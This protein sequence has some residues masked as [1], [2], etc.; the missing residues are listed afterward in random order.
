MLPYENKTITRR[1]MFGLAGAAGLTGAVAAC[2]GPGTTNQAKGTLATNGTQK[3]NVS[4]A[5]WRA[6]DKK[7]F[8][9]LIAKFEKEHKGSTVKQNISTSDDY[10]AQALQK[11]RRGGIGDVCPAFRGA[12][13]ENFVSAKLFVDLSD[14]GI[15]KKYKA[16][17]ITSGAKNGKQYGYPYQLVFL[18]PIANMDILSSAGFDEAPSNWDS[19]IDMLDKL[20]S[21]N[22]VPLVYP[23]ADAGN[24]GQ[25]FNSMIMNVAPSDDMCTKIEA[26]KYKCTDDWFLK[27]LG[28][29]KQLRPYLQ[30]NSS[31]TA[32]EPAE[33]MFATGKA[34]ML[35]TGSYHIASVRSLGAHFPIDL[36]PPVTSDK[37][38]AK[39]VG[40]Y[41]STF[42]LGIN[43][44]SKVQGAALAWLEFLSDKDNAATYANGTA[45]F[46]PVAGVEYTDPDLK[47][48]QPWLSKKTIL[49]PRYQFNNLDVRNAVEASCTKVLGGTAPEAAAEHAQK[50]VDQHVD[51]A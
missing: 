50:I 25:L 42:I 26:G 17:L 21:K 33:Q 31:G 29:Y 22:V 14:T 32:V 51:E 9:K 3:G 1:K 19:Y 4:F 7:V 10:Q 8:A 30:P 48:L 24:A 34:A 5:H 12:Q 15:T 27:M 44:A 37:G 40:S 13:F 49:A 39:Y 43:S 18:D 11:F 23:G 36:A 41:N 6:E 28:F 35:S 46:T 45:Q 47:A 20:K 16:D 38:K 2:A